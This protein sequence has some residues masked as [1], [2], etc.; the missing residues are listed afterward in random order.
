MQEE[1]RCP[2]IRGLTPKRRLSI[3]FN[4]QLQ[5]K[6]LKNDVEFVFCPDSS[7]FDEE[8]CSNN[9]KDYTNKEKLGDAAQILRKEIMS[10]KSVFSSWSP[11]E[12]KIDSKRMI[13]PKALEHFLDILLCAT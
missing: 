4:D 3:T 1:Q 10:L 12:K 5:Y 11:P 8:D 9:W 13:I 6:K 7:Q 2:F